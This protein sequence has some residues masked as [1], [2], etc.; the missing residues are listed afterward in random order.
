MG[1]FRPHSEIWTHRKTVA[2][3]AEHVFVELK[4]R[5]GIIAAPVLVSIR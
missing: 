1:R 5:Q 4:A 3:V 2:K